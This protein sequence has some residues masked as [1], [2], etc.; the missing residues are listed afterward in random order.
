[1]RIGISIFCRDFS[2]DKGDSIRAKR[3]LHV[4][5]KYYDV[6]I[7][8]VTTGYGKQDKI[9]AASRTMA[10]WPI[11]LIPVILRNRFDCIYCADDWRGFVAYHLLSKLRKYKIVFEAHAVASEDAREIAG[12]NKLKCR[13]AQILE[14]FVITHADYVIALS[15]NTL[16]FYR[17]YNS[18][19]ELVPVWVDETAYRRLARDRHGTGDCEVVGLIGPFDIPANRCFLEFLYNN[20]DRFSA[21]IRFVVI[22][23]CDNTRSDSRI[24]Y[25]GYI[26]RA[27][28]Y[29]RQ[30]LHL[31]A[32]IIP[33][34]VATTGPLNK[35]IEPM[36][37][38]LPVFT[39]PKGMV[40]L[41]WVRPDTDIFVFEED[42]LVD[43]VNE[44]IFDHELMGQVGGNARKVVEEYYSERANQD[45]LVRVLELVVGAE[46]AN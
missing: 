9:I 35:I 43:K 6:S 28:D 44:L 24:T 22:G 38:G 14:K 12:T 17:R 27:E 10:L 37:C 26:P 31:D 23:R 21:R 5:Q 39:T 33:A 29:V 19:I 46:Q 16:E 13:A 45:K 2:E 25:T 40:G 36:S 32:V 42:E 7:I 3:V 11:K 18:R 1:M 20:L 41:Y 34:R 15:K 30:L 4:L 8:T